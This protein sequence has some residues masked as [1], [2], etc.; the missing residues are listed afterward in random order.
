M[1]DFFYGY[2]LM[3]ICLGVICKSEKDS[4]IYDVNMSPKE[5]Q[6]KKKKNKKIN[7]L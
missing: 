5:R 2:L 4:S 1:K 6:I 3:G 7:P